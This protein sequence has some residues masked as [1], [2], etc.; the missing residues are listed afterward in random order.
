MHE[1][2]KGTWSPLWCCLSLILPYNQDLK[3]W[4]TSTKCSTMPISEAG[5]WKFASHLRKDRSNWPRQQPDAPNSASSGTYLGL[6][7]HCHSQLTLLVA[8]VPVCHSKG[9]APM[10]L[11]PAADS[12]EHKL[13]HV[14]REHSGS[15]SMSAESTTA[16]QLVLLHLFWPGKGR[17][18][19]VSTHGMAVPL[20]R[21]GWALHCCI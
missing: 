3:T 5:K 17:T 7:S 9:S 8:D 16:S 18:A 13:L 6:W 21:A 10:G 14:H 19:A 2:S 4:I 12:W 11:L 1:C 20:L 15:P